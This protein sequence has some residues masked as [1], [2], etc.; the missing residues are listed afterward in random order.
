V[1]VRAS[2]QI[3]PPALLRKDL[4]LKK[5]DRVMFYWW[6]GETRVLMVIGDDPT[7]EGYSRIS[8]E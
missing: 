5:N 6:P 1:L 2:G 7:D 3:M 8:S 4:K